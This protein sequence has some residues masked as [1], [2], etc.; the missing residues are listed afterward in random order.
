MLGASH[1]F[2]NLSFSESSQCPICGRILRGSNK[3]NLQRH[4]NLVHLKLKPYHCKYCGRSFGLKAYLKAHILTHTNSS[5]SRNAA[6]PADSVCD[7]RE[8][9]II[10]KTENSLSQAE[11]LLAALKGRDENFQGK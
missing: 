5:D 4:I 6:V 1:V 3:R 11:S 7:S 8:N 9:D 2:L 10:R